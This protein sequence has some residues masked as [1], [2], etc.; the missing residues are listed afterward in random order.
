M[1]VPAGIASDPA[2]QACRAWQACKAE[3]D[4]LTTRWQALET[5]LSR[6][7]NWYRLSRRQRAAIP[8]AAE[9]DVIDDCRDVVFDH[10][11]HLLV[12][13]PDISATTHLGIVAKLTVA[14]SVIHR[15]ENAEGHALITSILRDF[16]SMAGGMPE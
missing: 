14:A 12:A 6:Y 8:E 13:L 9:L 2:L 5:H 7:H 3:Y 4:A 15:D 16:R 11:Q 1:V 10:K